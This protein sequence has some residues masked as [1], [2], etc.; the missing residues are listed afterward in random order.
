[1]RS[2]LSRVASLAFTIVFIVS[3]DRTA[4]ASTLSSPVSPVDDAE[5]NSTAGSLVFVLSVLAVLAIGAFVT[6]KSR[7]NRRW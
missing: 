7:Q 1:M 5:V 3:F 4:N 6:W 2:T